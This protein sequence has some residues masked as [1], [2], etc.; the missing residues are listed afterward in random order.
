MC[1]WDRT[2]DT[3]NRAS[4]TSGWHR[5]DLRRTAATILGQLGVKPAVTDTLLC[6]L[7][8]YNREQVSA[9]APNYM[10]DTKIL[11]DA[12]DHERVAVNLLADALAS[13]C[14]LGESSHELRPLGH[15]I[16]APAKGS[17]PSWLDRKGSRPSSWCN[18]PDGLRA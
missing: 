5:H 7:N 17:M 1:N 10:I 6:H 9:A 15:E 4:G 11:S 3:I 13:I 18:F 8:P 12:I 16:S 2:Q 14:M